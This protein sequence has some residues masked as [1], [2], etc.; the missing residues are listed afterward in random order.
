[1]ADKKAG[2]VAAF[3]SLLLK[4]A[5]ALAAIYLA[6]FIFTT[7]QIAYYYPYEDD[8]TIYFQ[9]DEYLYHHAA[10]REWARDKAREEGEGREGVYSC[11]RTCSFDVDNEYYQCSK[12][13]PLRPLYETHMN[14]TPQTILGM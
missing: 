9:S 2:P 12:Q 11:G 10:C 5:L 14:I 1:M 13:S 7:K 4:M 6:M 3:K 8:T